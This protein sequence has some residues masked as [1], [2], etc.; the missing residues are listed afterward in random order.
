TSKVTITAS[1]GTPGYTYAYKQDGVAPVAAD[2]VASNVADLNPTTNAN[3]DVY[4]KDANG[5]IFP[6]NVAIDTD[7][8]P[9]V[10]AFVSNQCS[11]SGSSFT[12]TATP[13]ATSL[14]PL[15]YGIGGTTG[16][17]QSS[18]V[19]SVSAGTYTVWIKDANGCTS[20]SAA[21]TV[22]PQLTASAA[23]TRELSCSP[24]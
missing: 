9:G 15:T 17:F 1:G 12:I 24:T 13:S 23:V 11:G 8:T 14:A 18:P 2:Y 10:T 5:C 3:W 22:Y 7:D 21:V 20:P 19:F 4:I 16:A 6:L